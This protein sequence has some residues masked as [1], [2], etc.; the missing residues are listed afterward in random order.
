MAEDEFDFDEGGAE[1]SLDDFFQPAE[2]K[3]D[4]ESPSIDEFFEPPSGQAAGPAEGGDQLPMDRDQAQE[5]RQAA[6]PPPVAPGETGPGEQAPEQE[7]PADEGGEEGFL[8]RNWLWIV[9]G[10]VVVAVGLGGTY[11]AMSILFKPDVA[12]IVAADKPSDKKAAKKARE[13]PA[14]EK[15][16]QPAASQ[17]KPG[18]KAAAKTAPS[19][20]SGAEKAAPTQPTKQAEDKQAESEEL[21]KAAA[22]TGT[23]KKSATK[24]A[25]PAVRSTGGPYKVQVGAY[26][27]EASKK[28]PQE[29]LQKLGYSDYHYVPMSRS[30]KVYHV[31]VGEDLE[32]GEA[33]KIR[34]RLDSMGFK[35]EALAEPDGYKVR[36]YSYGDYGTARRTRE[37][38]RKAGL[39][40]VTIRSETKQVTLDQLRVGGYASRSQARKAQRHLQRSGFKGAII[41]KE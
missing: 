36:A 21:A 35:A 10:L 30:L 31:L 32:K 37:K 15:P 17:E 40:P 33:D 38:I 22:E 8:A 14:Q 20:N 25:K 1:A 13:R 12:E 19:K 27:L 16:A 24:N 34:T 41:V 3:P 9:I 39:S 23:G 28:Q 11:F 2:K 5:E 18:E 4:E 6:P 29:R 7:Q 26:M